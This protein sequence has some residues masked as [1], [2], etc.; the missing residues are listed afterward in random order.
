M[1]LVMRL[2]ALGV[3][4]S[5]A[6]ARMIVANALSRCVTCGMSRR[7]PAFVSYHN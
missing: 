2:L 1:I 5:S 3:K 6:A 4:P 7:F